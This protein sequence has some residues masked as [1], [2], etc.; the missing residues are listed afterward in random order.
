MSAGGFASYARSSYGVTL[1]E[2]EAERLR[3][4]FFRAYPGLKKWHSQCWRRAEQGENTARTVFG[5]M[6]LA[7]G[8]TTWCRF[9][10]HTA[11]T[12]SGSCADLIKSAMVK[13]AAALPESARLVATVHDELIMDCPAA[14]AQHCQ[15]LAEVSMKE[16][17]VEMFGSAV[18]VEVKAR[19]CTNW[20][21][22]Y[23]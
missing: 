9:N 6:L 4:R 13:V 20:G 14:A 19:G 18:P 16:A 3:E 2:S 7:Q 23:L 1:S 22:K 15:N 17:F 10:L 11:L 12:V 21:E 5:R 8:D